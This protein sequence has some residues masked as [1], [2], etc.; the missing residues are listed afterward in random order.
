MSNRSLTKDL[1]IDVSAEL[2]R[3]E[4]FSDVSMR[5]IAKK[6]DVK[7]SSLY[8]HIDSKY[9]ILELIIFDIVDIFMTKMKI[10]MSKDLNTENKLIDI[11]Q[12]HINIAINKTNA[13]ATLNNDWKYLRPEKKKIFIDRRKEYEM[14]L[15]EIIQ[16][17]QK[18][19]DITDNDP[20]IIIYILLTSLR[21]IHLWYE[22]NIQK[23]TTLLEE[24]PRMLLNGVLT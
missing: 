3:K 16:D 11:I 8:N 18:K 24:I 2:F 4:S 20:E 6:L 5:D 14:F 19:R 12:T 23:E 17:G 1:I 22:K 7:A 21:T 9:E 13:F 10:T 15:K